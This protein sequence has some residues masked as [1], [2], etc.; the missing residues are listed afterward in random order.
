MGQTL[1]IMVRQGL[2]MGQGKVKGRSD[3]NKVFLKCD[4]CNTEEVRLIGITL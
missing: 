4:T 1:T 3:D 2:W